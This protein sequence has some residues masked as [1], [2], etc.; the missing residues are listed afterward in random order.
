PLVRV[1]HRGTGADDI[2]H[3][4]AEHR[5]CFPTDDQDDVAEAGAHGVVHAVIQQ[6]L[7]MR[8]DGREL[9]ETAV[10]SPE[11]RRED[12]ESA[13]W[14]VRICSR[15]VLSPRASCVSTVFVPMPSRSAI[16][17]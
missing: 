6:C 16:W 5:L 17:A 12:D 9:F 13:Y 2:R 7:A 14:A 11:A 4:A 15:T 3:V 1:R 8:P 10:A